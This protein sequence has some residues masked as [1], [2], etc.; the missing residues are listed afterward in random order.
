MRAVA[1]ESAVAVGGKGWEEV[2]VD[3]VPEFDH[4]SYCILASTPCIIIR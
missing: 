2:V 4:R 3:E 1:D